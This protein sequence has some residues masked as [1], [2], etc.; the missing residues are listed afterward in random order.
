MPA[1]RTNI[2]DLVHTPAQRGPAMKT[3]SKGLGKPAPTL[4]ATHTLGV[5][6]S[7]PVKNEIPEGG[8][9]TLKGR[10]S[11]PK[12]GRR[13]RFINGLFMITFLTSQGGNIA[14]YKSVCDGL[15]QGSPR[16]VGSALRNNPFAPYVPCHRVIASDLYL[17][18]YR[19]EWGPQSKSGTQFNRKLQLLREE[20][21]EFDE[22]GMLQ[23]KEKLI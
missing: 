17:G 6:V 13:L 16:S 18:G 21:I 23:S 15:G 11:A 1:A 5:T 4:K 19:G 2:W 9:T 20:G 7:D 3:T 22:K 10:T 12:R 14:T 8:Q